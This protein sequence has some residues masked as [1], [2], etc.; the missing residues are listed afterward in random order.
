MSDGLRVFAFLF[1]IGFA[2]WIYDRVDHLWRRWQLGRTNYLKG[3]L[4]IWRCHRS[5]GGGV[6][7]TPHAMTKSEAVDWCG[8][9]L[10]FIMYVDEVHH[11][12][13]YRARN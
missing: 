1:A 5:Q 2:L 9:N 10:G 7:E 3:S 13:F 4:Y 6:V 12:I 8:K 11:F